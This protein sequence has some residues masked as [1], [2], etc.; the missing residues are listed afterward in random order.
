MNTSYL[1][2]KVEVK[3]PERGPDMKP[4]GRMTTVVGICKRE[5]GPNELLDVPL[6]ITVDNMPIRINSLRDIR[7]L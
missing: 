5:P 4:T 7:I 3:I 6:Q 2:K 1:G